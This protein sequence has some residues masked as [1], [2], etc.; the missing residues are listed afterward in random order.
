MIVP[1]NSLCY[2]PDPPP[3]SEYMSLN[4]DR[5]RFMVAESGRAAL[6]GD[7]KILR[8]GNEWV[9]WDLLTALAVQVVS[10]GSGQSASPRLPTVHRRI[11]NGSSAR[12]ETSAVH[13][14]S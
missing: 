9:K 2:V 4:Y 1:R 5:L 10:A 12:M 3:Q 6:E 8:T 14:H 11:S 13:R 7:G